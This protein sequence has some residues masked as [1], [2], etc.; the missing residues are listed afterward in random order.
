MPYCI[1]FTSLIAVGGVCAGQ[2]S[3]KRCDERSKRG[4]KYGTYWH[5]Q[6]HRFLEILFWKFWFL[7]FLAVREMG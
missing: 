3:A 4:A 2:S 5:N 7:Y 1:D 6:P